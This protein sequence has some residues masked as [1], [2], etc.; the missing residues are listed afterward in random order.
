MGRARSALRDRG[1]WPTVTL[2]YKRDRTDLETASSPT[3]TLNLWQ[4]LPRE[5]FGLCKGGHGAHPELCGAL[6]NIERDQ[7]V[8]SRAHHVGVGQVAEP[9]YF[10]CNTEGGDA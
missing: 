10:L 6:E 8:L 3:V 7:C 1:S 4:D 9:R 2:T 5:L